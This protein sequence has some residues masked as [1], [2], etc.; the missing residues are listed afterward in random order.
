MIIGR[1]IFNNIFKPSVPL[2][3]SRDPYYVHKL[4]DRRGNPDKPSFIFKIS[5]FN[6]KCAPSMDR[7]ED[8]VLLESRIS[9]SFFSARR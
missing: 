6:A 1:P 7:T 4:N 2:A 5:K 8:H 9:V 3:D